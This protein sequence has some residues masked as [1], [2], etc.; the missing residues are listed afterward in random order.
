[1]AHGLA[2]AMG[3]DAGE[4]ADRWAASGAMFLT[5]HADGPALVAPARVALA[6]DHLAGAVSRGSAAVGRRIEVDGPALLGERAALAGLTRCGPISC[7]GH[8]RLLRAADAWVALTVARAEDVGLLDAWLD[9]RLGLPESVPLDDWSAIAAVVARRSAADL[10]ERAALLGLP[11]AALC[12]VTQAEPLIRAGDLRRHN[13]APRSLEN[14]TVVDLSALW[15][16]PLCAQLLGSA[17]ARVIKV[18]SVSRP[19][20][21]RRGPRR[22]YD[23]LHAGH[24]SVALDFGTADGRIALVDL[25]CSADVVIEASRPRA[26]EA[27]SASYAD[28][29]Q[30]SWDGMW[31]SITAYGRAG[32][33]RTRAGF[34]DDAA[35]AG[36]LVAGTADGPVFCADA[37]ADPSTGLLGA[38]AVMSALQHGCSGLLEVSLAATAAHLAA[39]V[40][41]NDPIEAADV[42]P[43]RPM[44]RVATG[45]APK[46]GEHTAVLLP[47][48]AGGDR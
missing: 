43:A 41:G 1:M 14:A 9:E 4:A 35:V 26:L 39:G 23:L 3:G 48:S 36:G 19:D 7:G 40:A 5:G 27:L 12:E 32:A 42:E 30:R 37:I 25:L 17:G 8:C 33:A 15:A 2:T 46:M 47:T 31:L 22:F 10:S 38:V 20:G 13:A 11:A 44:A 24:E 45:R 28:L 16:G 29:R 34:G 6:L 21:A 18:E